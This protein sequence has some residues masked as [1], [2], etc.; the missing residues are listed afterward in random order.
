MVPTLSRLKWLWLA[1]A[2]YYPPSL[3]VVHPFA[4]IDVIVPL[5][6]EGPDWD[7]ERWDL[8]A[9]WGFLQLDVG[10]KGGL[11]RNSNRRVPGLPFWL[12]ASA[13]ARQRPSR[14]SLV[15]SLFQLGFGYTGVASSGGGDPSYVM[16]TNGRAV[17]HLIL[18]S[19]SMIHTLPWLLLSLPRPLLH[20]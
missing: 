2:C 8:T 13:S 7:Y 4:V 16:L 10:S 9:M 14:L 11:L 17:T 1:P 19:H 12:P 5:Y 20:R 6:C 15:L 3:P 18:Q